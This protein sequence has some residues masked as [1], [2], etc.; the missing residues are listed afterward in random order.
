MKELVTT[1]ILISVSF[2]ITSVNAQT[3]GRGLNICEIENKNYIIARDGACALQ[4]TL[5]PLQ[6]QNYRAKNRSFFISVYKKENRFCLKAMSR[7]GIRIASLHQD[8][9][10]P[11]IYLISGDSDTIIKQQDLSTLL[12]IDIKYKH[13]EPYIVE[14]SEVD[15]EK[16][17]SS[18]VEVEKCL[19]TEDPYTKYIKLRGLGRE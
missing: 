13:V 14:T 3:I 5:L 4:K 11:G 7:N 1:L 2:S 18:V 17:P 9:N 16:Q 19:N 8:P 6:A 15:A 12:Y 10:N